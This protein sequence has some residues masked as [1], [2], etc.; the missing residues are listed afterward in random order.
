MRKEVYNGWYRV[1]EMFPPRPA[2]ARTGTGKYVSSEAGE[3]WDASLR[4]LILRLSGAGFTA[5]DL[6]TVYLTL[7]R[8]SEDEWARVDKRLFVGDGVHTRHGWRI[9]L[10]PEKW[11]AWPRLVHE[12]GLLPHEATDHILGGAPHPFPY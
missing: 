2:A 9:A 7:D 10:V 3:V 6:Y 4:E 5:Q 1:L 8:L 11:T 12:D